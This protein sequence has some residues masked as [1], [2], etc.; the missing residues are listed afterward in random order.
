MYTHAID[1]SE[2]ALRQGKLATRRRTSTSILPALRKSK[3]M[4]SA[5]RATSKEV[6]P[7]LKN[8]VMEVLTIRVVYAFEKDKAGSAW[9]WQNTTE[10]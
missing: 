9:E 2:H 7:G 3:Q 10:S 6:L 1:L 8:L 5:R 4:S